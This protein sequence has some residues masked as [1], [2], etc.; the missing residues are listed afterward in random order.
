[1][2][3][4]NILAAALAAASTLSLAI[5]AAITLATGSPAAFLTGTAAFIALAITATT[6]NPTI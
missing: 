5:G 4:K 1:M 2:K 3:T 6:I